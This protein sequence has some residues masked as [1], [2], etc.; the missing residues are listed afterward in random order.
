LN[1]TKPKGNLI[2]K[3]HEIDFID[4]I[5]IFDDPDRMEFESMRSGEKRIQTIG[6]IHEVVIFLVYTLRGKNKRIISARRASKNER[7]AYYEE[8]N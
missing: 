5:K 1:G 4:G 3:K 6:K 8:K 7:K 2:S